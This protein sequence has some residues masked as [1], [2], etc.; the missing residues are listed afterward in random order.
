MMD[1]AATDKALEYFK[2]AD[3]YRSKGLPDYARGCERKALNKLEWAFQL[4]H[5]PLY[6][7][8]EPV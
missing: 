6:P 4:R 2:R 1:Q 8:R 5:W 3:G 7:V